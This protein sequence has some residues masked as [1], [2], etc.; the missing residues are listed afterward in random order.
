MEK[1]HFVWL[2]DDSDDDDDDKNVMKAR[3][4]SM[5]GVEKHNDDQ[6]AVSELSHFTF[7]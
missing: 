3:S 4:T 2:N 1:R 7:V 6:A 5:K